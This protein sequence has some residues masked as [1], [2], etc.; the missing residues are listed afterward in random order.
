MKVFQ[1]ALIDR[2]STES[3][4]YFNYSAK[5][6]ITYTLWEHL[7]PIAKAVPGGFIPGPSWSLRGAHLLPHDVVVYF[8]NDPSQSIARKLGVP[9]PEL[10]NAG[11]L[12]ANTSRGTVCEVYVEGNMPARRLANIAF[13]EIMHNKLDVG[14][15]WKGNLHRDA[16]AGLAQKPTDE[17]SRLTDGN[18]RV[19]SANLFRSVRQYIGGI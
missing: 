1:I 18:I 12:T 8:V 4:D 7:V 14:G 3:A 6:T 19:M 5:N 10:A 2:V 17:W 13:H 11:G 15:G 16:G 9:V